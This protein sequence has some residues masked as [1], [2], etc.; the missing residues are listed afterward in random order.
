[1]IVT[2]KITK[3]AGISEKRRLPRL[4]KIRLGV[5]AINPKTGNEYPK[6]VDYFVVPPEV[7]K[8]YGEKPK[9]LD[10]MFPINNIEVIFPQAYKWYG[11]TKGL[12]CIGNGQ[13]AYRLD[14]KTG[15]MI[16]RE[17]PCE[18]LS[19]NGGCM[20]RGHLLVILPRVNMGGVYQIDVGSY[21]SIININ[22]ALEYIE[23]LIGRFA[24]VPLKLRR[25]P[26]EIPYEGKLRTHYPLQIFFEGD[27][28]L[29]NA[30]REDNKRIIMATENLALPAPEDINP[31][32]DPEAVV[33][34]EN[35]ENEDE[36]VNENSQTTTVTPVPAKKVAT[37]P[38]SPV[39][40]PAPEVKPPTDVQLNA[41]RNIALRN[42][43]DEGII[44]T[45]LSQVASIKDASNIITTFGK[46]DFTLLDKFI[47]ELDVEEVE[48]PE[49]V[50]TQE[51]F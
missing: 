12:K 9:E 15:E 38:K 6:E 3:V 30:L 4:G 36:S 10:I 21:N 8:V 23:A 34:V 35:G 41:I 28:N 50:T 1:M 47:A 25:V 20:L 27:I 22:S 33:V 43:Y 46:G 51:P 49:E 45:F 5:K 48:V 19:N 17:C 40:K 11:D 7:A 14:E 32:H 24:M 37:A 29:I 31:K 13:I 16:E 39:Q 44:E 18:I 26:K 2:Q 42:G